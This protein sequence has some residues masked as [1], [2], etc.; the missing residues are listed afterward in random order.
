VRAL[1]SAGHAPAGLRVHFGPSICGRCYEVGPDVYRQL[2][3]LETQRPRHVD[4]RALLGEQATSLGIGRWSA[5]LDCTR[6]DNDRFFSHRAGDAGRQIGV[7]VR[8]A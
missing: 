1:E 5:D 7:I 8:S 4:L 2:T 6:C 3:G